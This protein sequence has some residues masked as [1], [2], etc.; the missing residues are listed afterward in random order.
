MTPPSELKLY[1]VGETSGDPAEWS[2]WGDRVLVI[3]RS[4]EEAMELGGINCAA[5]I[6][7]RTPMIIYRE[8]SRDPAD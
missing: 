5:E 1:V 7:L 8:S 4:A 6:P 2:E 3:A